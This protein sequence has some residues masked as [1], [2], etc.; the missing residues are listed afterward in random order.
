LQCQTARMTK[1]TPAPT[2]TASNV[3]TPE[4][5]L[6]H[7]Q[8]HRTLTRRVID[9]F[10][11]DQ[12]FAFSIGGMRTFGQLASEMLNM[13]VPMVRG[14]AS[15]SWEPYSTAEI[16]SKSELLRLWDDSTAQMNELWPQIPAERFQEHM[17]AFGQFPGHVHYL[18]MYVID[19]E[20]HH[21]GQGYVYLRALGITPPPFYERA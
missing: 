1:T 6:A 10:P 12:L 21:R 8:G 9:A 13:A 7:W 15:G 17:T 11:E 20:V 2:T 5:L 4:Q 19:N 3:I 18:L 16:R 14:V